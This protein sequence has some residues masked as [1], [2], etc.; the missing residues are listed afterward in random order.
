LVQYFISKYSKLFSKQVTGARHEVIRFLESYD[1]PGNVRE[2]ENIIER[3][4]VFS[5]GLLITMEDMP[6]LHFSRSSKDDPAAL[7]LAG[8]TLAE[9]EREAILDT[10]KATGQNRKRAAG[11]LGI[12]ERTLRN[13]LDFYTQ[14]PVDQA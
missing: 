6:Q 9:I 7:R 13:K 1:F 5:E 8:K 11:L 4:V 3:A 14:F 10:L 2:L 12:T